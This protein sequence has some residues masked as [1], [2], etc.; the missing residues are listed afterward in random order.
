[1][2]GPNGNLNLEEEI[3]VGPEEPRGVSSDFILQ[4]ELADAGSLQVA[5]A[6]RRFNDG[7]ETR[8][9]NWQMDLYRPGTFV[10][11]V[12]AI[13]QSM[14]IILNT[15]PGSHPFAPEFGTGIFERLDQELPVVAPLLAADVKRDL[16][17]WEPRI[18]V[19][20]VGYRYIT[21]YGELTGNLSGVL[22]DI[23]WRPKADISGEQV[24]ELIA[25]PDG[26]VTGVGPDNSPIYR[27][28]ATSAGR[29]IQLSNGRNVRLP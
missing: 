9:G 19:D 13:E 28:L 5:A 1:M 22:F 7:R 6:Q 21:S 27:I 23:H 20:R 14:Y 25:I 18:L 12:E 8:S 17:R 11:G 26:L 2:A 16:A 4:D 24:S 10:E 15:V 3:L 29:F